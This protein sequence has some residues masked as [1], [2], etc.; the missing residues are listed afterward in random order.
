MS[1]FIR[2]TVLSGVVASLLLVPAMGAAQGRTSVKV[3]QDGNVEVKTGNTEVKTGGAGT[4]VRTGDTEVETQGGG[5]EGESAQAETQSD[6][7]SIEIAGM[8]AKETHRCSSKTEVDVS[9]SDNDVTLTGDCKR[10]SVSGSG[11]KVNVEAVG[12][13][14]VMGANNAVTWK[15]AVG[16]KKPKVSRSGANNKVTQAK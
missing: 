11:N 10:V 8:G 9:G 4:S 5:E 1:K 3:G 7:A 14:D 15:K 13:I 6:D 2:G 12:A 16:G